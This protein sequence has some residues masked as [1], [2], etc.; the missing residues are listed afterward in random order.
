VNTASLAG[1]VA[2]PGIGPYNAS[3]FAVVAISETLHQELALAGSAVKV[4]VLCPGF[5]RTN[6]LDSQRNRPEHLSVARRRAQPEALERNDA[7]RRIFETAM[8]PERVAELV[9]DAIRS[10]RFWIFTHPEML[11]AV[12]ARTEFI[13]AGQNPDVGGG[14]WAAVPTEGAD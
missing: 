9:V 10:E 4:S 8:P 5:V 1:L 7:I 2:G 6:I 12:S 11:P 13:L 3:K 14:A